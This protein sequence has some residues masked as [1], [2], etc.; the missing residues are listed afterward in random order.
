[1]NKKRILFYTSAAGLLAV[2]LFVLIYVGKEYYRVLIKSNVRIGASSKEYLYIPTNAT[3]DNVLDS[4]RKGNFLISEESFI[5]AAKR[6]RYTS[7]VKPGRY[8]LKQ[9]MSNK[10]LI[11]ALS[12]GEQE[13]VNLVIAGHIRN[14]KKLAAVLSR[15]MEADS[16]QYL[17]ALQNDT[18][19]SSLGFT[20]PTFMSMFIPNTYQVYW[21]SS[22]EATLRR[23]KREYEKFWDESRRR[24]AE[25][26]QYSQVEVAIIASIVDEETNKN[27]EMSRI[28]GVYINRLKQ[29]IP[30]Q[31]DPTLKYAL[32]NF[33]IKRV[34]NAHMTIESPYN[35]YKYLGL[36]PGPICMPS[37]AA[38]DAVLNYEKHDYLYFCAKDDFSG[39]HAFA[40][41]LTQHN[42]NAFKYRQALN[43]NR[44][45]R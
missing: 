8:R 16:L 14:Y 43:R 42:H 20:M 12:L 22:P 23:L 28:A 19:V 15:N 45:F 35:T 4:L 40:K 11:R 26:M 31:A 36:P 27:D 38:I 21:N 18:L 17:V 34:L 33:S 9:D 3:F 24:K 1:M 30:L 29:G 41:T 32:E 44:V 39:Y 7:G 13:A 25:T 2:I 37:I 5:N 10:A 6:G